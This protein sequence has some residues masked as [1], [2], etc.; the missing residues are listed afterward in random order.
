VARTLSLIVVLVAGSSLFADTKKGI[1]GY[2]NGTL[3]VGAIELRVGFK[4]ETKDGKLT[5]T[6]DS[7][8]QGGKNIPIEQ[9]EFADGKIKLGMPKMKASYTGTLDGD[10]IKGEFDQVGKLPLDLKR[11]D[12]PVTLKRPQHP[13]KPYPYVEEEV[14]FPSKVKEVTLAGTFTKPHGDGRFSAVVLISGSG[15]Q[16]RDES[17]LG[18]KPFLVLADHLARNGIAVLRFDD[19]GVGKSTGDFAKATSRDFADDVAGAVAYLKGR[20]DVDKIGLMG[21]SEGGLIAPMVAA[22]DR[23]IAFM[24]LLAGPGVPGDQILVAQG[25]LILK[26]MGAD[27]KGLARQRKL[28]ERLLSLAKAGADAAKLKD[29]FSETQ[30]E[31]SDAEKK[32]LQ[33]E[34]DAAS[35]QIS[36]LAT[37][38]FRYFLSYDPRPTLAIVR[39]PVLAINGELDLQ[40]PCKENLAEIEKALKAGGN[41]NVTVKEFPGLNH[42]FQTTKT[43]LPSEY[44]KIEETF[45]PEALKLI[46]EWIRQRR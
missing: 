6:M 18:H 1:E 44:G 39:C 41:R 20:P 43:G 35:A 45:S 27:E 8:D 21:H 26:A 5:A 23:R 3:K 11:G 16:D 15:P 30:A 17:L 9:V 29:A 36:Q 13:T 19:R 38:W 34:L 37:P 10:T 24:V 31:F 14:T 7:I 46:S 33:K 32:T 4:I 25:Q 42:L 22:G 40:V 2:W 28:Q 12:K